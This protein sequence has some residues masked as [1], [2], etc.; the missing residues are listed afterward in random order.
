MGRPCDTPR[1]PF[2]TGASMPSSQ[3]ARCGAVREGRPYDYYYG[4]LV[5]ERVISDPR[6]PNRSAIAT[7]YDIYGAGS[8][9]LCD[10]CVEE[11]LAEQHRQRAAEARTWGFALFAP[12]VILVLLEV[13]LL[14][15]RLMHYSALAYAGLCTGV[16]LIVGGAFALRLALS[17][18]TESGR[19]EAGES[20]AIEAGRQ[21]QPA[22]I[23]F[24]TSREYNRLGKPRT[25]SSY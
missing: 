4:V 16:V 15:S 1:P 17:R 7:R 20:L 3:C 14:V 8:A 5:E 6:S 25:R 19:Q 13:G 21:E 22:H 18:P 10:R 2:L 23:Q 9:F 12:G 24:W 11:R